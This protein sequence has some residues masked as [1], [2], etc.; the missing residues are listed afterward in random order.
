MRKVCVELLN[1]ILEREM[2]GTIERWL[3]RVQEHK[4]STETKQLRD[5]ASGVRSLILV[6]LHGKQTVLIKS[7]LL[8]KT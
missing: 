5:I 8:V 7:P 2:E 6:G 1:S 4:H 3:W